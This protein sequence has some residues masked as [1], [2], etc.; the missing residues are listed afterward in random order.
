M[1]FCIGGGITVFV[2]ECFKAALLKLDKWDCRDLETKGD[3]DYH[4]C[5]TANYLLAAV[6]R[7]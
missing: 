5:F 6:W 7:V 1:D 2:T 3:T 4:L